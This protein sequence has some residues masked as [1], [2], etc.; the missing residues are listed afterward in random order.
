MNNGIIKE[1][2]VMTN[3]KVIINMSIFFIFVILSIF[4]W[5]YTLLLIPVLYEVLS[6]C[7]KTIKFNFRSKKR[8]IQN[9]N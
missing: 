3:N 6:S 8:G 5:D 9:E 7:W 2:E 4:L 1:Q